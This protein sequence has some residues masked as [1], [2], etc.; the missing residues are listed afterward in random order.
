MTKVKRRSLPRSVV[1]NKLKLTKTMRPRQSPRR[2]LVQRRLKP[3]R[4]MKPLLQ[5]RRL[6]GRKHLSRRKKHK[7]LPTRTIH[8]LRRSPKD[9]SQKLPPRSSPP[10][11]WEK[12]TKPKLKKRTISL[13]RP[14]RLPR[15]RARAE[16]R[17]LQTSSQRRVFGL[18][19]CRHLQ[20]SAET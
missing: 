5:P 18:V 10:V 3:R 20:A 17:R 12:L 15:S 2:S 9:A 1:V 11:M 4:K 14:R 7:I 8:R 6:Q 16:P 13:C 19:C